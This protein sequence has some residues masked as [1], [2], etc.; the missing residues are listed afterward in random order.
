MK[1]FIITVLSSL[2]VV[3]CTSCTEQ[4]PITVNLKSE[5][6]C[7]VFYADKEY[8]CHFQIL[9]DGVNT[10]TIKSPKEIS[11]LS[12]RYA[13]GIYSLCYGELCCK[14][15]VSLLPDNSFTVLALK[16]MQSVHTAPPQLQQNND[17]YIYSNDKFT[18][19]TDE[20]GNITELK[21]K[22]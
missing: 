9:G 4:K 3:S 8:E 10:V 6:D 15:T 1:K 11:G 5:Q 16:A 21:L 17:S 18:L 20:S 12:F 19:I 7:K 14:N 22:S 2:A 13:D